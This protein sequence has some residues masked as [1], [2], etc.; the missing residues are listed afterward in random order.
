MVTIFEGSTV[1]MLATKLHL[2]TREGP[3]ECREWKIALR[4]D[5]D[6]SHHPKSLNVIKNM[7]LWYDIY[8]GA[9][10]EPQGLL[11]GFGSVRG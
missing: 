8:S 1:I 2:L 3:R 7:A 4:G 10:Y 5:G 9:T 6:H 11:R